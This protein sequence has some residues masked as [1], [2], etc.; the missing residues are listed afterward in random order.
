MA[1]SSFEGRF[2]VVREDFQASSEFKKSEMNNKYS[3]I[4]NFREK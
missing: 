4:F 3:S 2:S 1:H